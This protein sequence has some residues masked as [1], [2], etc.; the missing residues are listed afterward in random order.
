M[1]GYS[2][3]GDLTVVAI[4][5]VMIVL[6]IF[7]YVRNS[8]S[9]QIFL[10]IVGVLML[11]ALSNVGSYALANIGSPEC[12][13]AAY[14]IRCVFHG[15]LFSIFILFTAYIA[16]VARLERQRRIPYLF[17]AGLI[18]LTVVAVDAIDTLHLMRESMAEHGLVLRKR[19]IF[20][21]GY[22][23]FAALM[24][25]MLFKVRKAV[26]RQVM[27]GFY[28]TIAISFGMLLIQGLHRQT[29]F[30]VVSFLFPVIGMFYTLHSNPYDAQ[31]GTID[32]RALV[33][34]VRY[35]Y[36]KK[37][38]FVYMSLY[39]RTFDEEGVMMPEE[40]QA[41]IRKFSI[42]YFRGAVLFQAGKSHSILMIMKNRNPDYR[43]RIRNI[44]QGFYAEYAKYGYDYK[45]VIGESTEELSRKNEYV[46]FI[47][48]IHAQMEEN[49]IHWV[50]PEDVARFNRTEYIL[51][52][53]EDISRQ[54]NLD[55]PR[56]LAYCQ[57]VYNIREQRYDTAEA[58]MRL[59]LDDLGLVFPDQFIP[60]AEA[61]NCIH[62]LTEI[63]LHKTCEAVRKLTGEGYQVRRISVNVS[64]MELQDEHFCDDIIDIIQKSQVPG[65]KI[66]IELTES[67]TDSDFR[68]MKEKIS[69]LRQRGI[70]FYLDD[71]GTGYSNME[72]IMALP[73]DIIKF[74]RSMVLA[75]GHSER[76]RKIVSSLANIFAEMNYSVLYEGVEQQQDEEMCEHMSASYLQGYRYSRPVP[77]EAL[78][79]YFAK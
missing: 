13:A 61:N 18:F 60:L 1:T 46:S 56:V 74:D 51:H 9:F 31:L 29:S 17:A 21:V 37:R 71:F 76:S 75:S 59:R 5:A 7:S 65:E 50:E 48:S 16:E 73:F 35:N 30:T 63:I 42:D 49:T 26:Y 41:L 25:F 44:L 69:E 43:E 20:L 28:G 10:S 72:R 11:A 19:N 2:P 52:E 23:V 47:R 79:D 24:V 3:V 67:Q 12:V 39:L 34:A 14:V 70:K 33:D 32:S 45:M 4:C 53:L 58:L 57:P 36:E 6:L 68:V 55:D 77:I 22:L 62:A 54:R 8:R 78:K 64:A 27:R 40:I 38:D 66:A 15:L